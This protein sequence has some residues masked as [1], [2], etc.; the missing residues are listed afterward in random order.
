MSVAFCMFATA[1]VSAGGSGGTTIEVNA[2]QG[3]V[4]PADGSA[5]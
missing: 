4:T 5:R 1:A 3:V 2:G